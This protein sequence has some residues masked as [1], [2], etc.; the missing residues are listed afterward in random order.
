MPLLIFTTSAEKWCS[1]IKKKKIIDRQDKVISLIKILQWPPSHSGPRY[2]S[3]LISVAVPP[4]TPLLAV[5]QMC[6]CAFTPRP[7]HLPFPPFGKFFTGYP[8]IR[9]A[10][11]PPS[12]IHSNATSST[13]SLLVPYFTL[14]TPRPAPCDQHSLALHS[15]P[16]DVSHV[17]LICL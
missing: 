4:V 3:A 17:L 7:L 12:S 14:Q 5:P 13:K 9:V 6:P 16:S 2:L 15:S 10:P 11:L 1:L 8:S